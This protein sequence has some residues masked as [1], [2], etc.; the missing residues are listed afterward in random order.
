MPYGQR[1]WFVVCF[2]CYL[3]P[4]GKRHAN[5][6]VRDINHARFITMGEESILFT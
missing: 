2:Y 6:N 3:C 5:G 4:T 1:L